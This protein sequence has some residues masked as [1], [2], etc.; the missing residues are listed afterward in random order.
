MAR[1]F[2]PISAIWALARAQAP[3]GAL[4]RAQ[5]PSTGT[6]GWYPGICTPTLGPWPARAQAPTAARSSPGVQRLIQE[7]LARAQA[8]QHALPD[9]NTLAPDVKTVKRHPHKYLPYHFYLY[10]MLE[11]A[12]THA[13]AAAGPKPKLFR[14]LPQLKM[15]ARCITLGD[16]A[17]A[18]MMRRV[19]QQSTTPKAEAQWKQTLH[20]PG[21]GGLF[22]QW[23]TTHSGAFRAR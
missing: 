2:C 15:K 21:A 3:A 13:Q 9:Q 19:A 1:S 4:A 11:E 7:A 6:T 18:R 14:I 20:E 23:C 16:T 5:A 10:K 17:L 12:R 22:R 8:H